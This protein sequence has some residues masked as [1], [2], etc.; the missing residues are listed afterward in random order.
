MLPD[1]NGI[2]QVEKNAIKLRQYLLVFKDIV[3]HHQPLQQSSLRIIRR[4]KSAMAQAG[5]NLDNCC[6]WDFTG[7]VQVPDQAVYASLI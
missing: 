2:E 6:V 7:G 4:L 3:D 5:D 1:C